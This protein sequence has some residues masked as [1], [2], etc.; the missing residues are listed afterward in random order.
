MYKIYMKGKANLN[1]SESCN[2]IQGFRGR[3]LIFNPFKRNVYI[4]N[5]GRERV[6]L[7]RKLEG[8]DI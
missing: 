4:L 1:E 2:R 8:G 7:R 3:Y 6:K 5:S